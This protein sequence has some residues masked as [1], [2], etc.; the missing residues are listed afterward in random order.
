MRLG[1]GLGSNQNKLPA[2]WFA[3]FSHERAA[4]L[5]PHCA[6]PFRFINFSKNGQTTILHCEHRVTTILFWGS[7]SKKDGRELLCVAQIT[8][9]GK[10]EVGFS[11]L[12]RAVEFPRFLDINRLESQAVEPSVNQ[13]S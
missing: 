2:L 5:I 3:P 4:W 12:M 11:P 9:A 7:A 8:I 1:G 6:H 10:R 13:K